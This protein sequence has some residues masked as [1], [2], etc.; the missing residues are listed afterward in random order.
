MDKKHNGVCVGMYG[1]SLSVCHR[2]VEKDET[3]S[4]SL[5]KK[6]RWNDNLVQRIRSVHKPFF[7]KRGFRVQ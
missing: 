4:I 3:K 1:E 2:S 7:Q 6:E 5:C